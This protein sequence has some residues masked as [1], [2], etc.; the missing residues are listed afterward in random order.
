MAS[1]S[2]VP[3]FDWFTIVI[4]YDIIIPRIQ[5]SDGYYSLGG[6]A[7]CSMCSRGSAC[8]RPDTTPTPCPPGTYSLDGS[9][10]CT[11]C[12]AGHTCRDPSSECTCM[13]S[14]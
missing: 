11:L 9:I 1:Q 4:M 13:W 10:N 7:S 14:V 3:K 5:C 12:D 2:L 8:P 6:V